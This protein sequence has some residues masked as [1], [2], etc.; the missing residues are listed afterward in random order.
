MKATAVNRG[1]GL[2][3]LFLIF[4]TPF[5]SSPIYRLQEPFEIQPDP[6]NPIPE[7]YY[8]YQ[9]QVDMSGAPES[10]P[11][12][13][14]GFKRNANWFWKKRLEM[15]PE[16]FSQANAY[17]VKVL[18]LAPQVDEV[19]V[20][21]NAAHTA[22]SRVDPATGKKM[23]L[24]HHHVNQG[25]YAV[26]LPAEVHRKWSAIL[27]Q[28]FKKGMSG[29][30]GKANI[31]SAISK[32]NKGLGVAGLILDLK[33]TFR[34]DPHS[35]FIEFQPISGNAKPGQVYY[36]YNTK[37]YIVAHKIGEW[38]ESPASGL[39]KDWKRVAWIS[40]YV[41]YAWDINIKKYAGIGLLAEGYQIYYTN[42][43]YRNVQTRCFSDSPD[44]LIL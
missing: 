30:R 38:Q 14:A 22:F 5:A 29:L 15:N 23:A 27:H 34:G 25:N 7:S 16:M 42:G 19:W 6:G 26:A 4:S 41:D 8:N 13:A 43:K 37:T 28:R 44:C 2:S 36:D 12:N 31:K 10:S 39:H 1:Y 11:V 21:Y 20:K 24:H 3:L 9:P 32:M 35:L 17:R 18:G 40:Q 33:G